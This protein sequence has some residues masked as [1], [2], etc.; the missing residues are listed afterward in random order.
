VTV[1]ELARRFDDLVAAA[2]RI[3]AAIEALVELAREE[4][5]AA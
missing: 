1:E 4:V 3:A 5:E 2:E